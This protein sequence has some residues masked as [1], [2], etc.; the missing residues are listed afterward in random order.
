MQTLYKIVNGSGGRCSC[1]HL[2]RIGKC[3]YLVDTGNRAYS[4]CEQCGKEQGLNEWWGAKKEITAEEMQRMWFGA[5]PLKEVV[6]RQLKQYIS[7]SKNST[8]REE[9][10]RV[11]VDV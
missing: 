6:C 2:Q 8:K 10:L 3:Y 7:K 11:A 5:E 9:M 4:V 1:G